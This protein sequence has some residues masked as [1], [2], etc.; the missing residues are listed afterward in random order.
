MGNNRIPHQSYGGGDGGGMEAR[1]AVL[2]TKM[3]HIKEG[4]DKLSDVP[5][6]LAKLEVKVDHL[7][8]K[9][10]VVTA[11]LGTIGGVV[12]LLGLLQHLG[13]LK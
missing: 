6:R 10:F 2:E 9:S 5:V 13:I 7:P 11:A 8:S 4:L 1:V 12:T 3:E